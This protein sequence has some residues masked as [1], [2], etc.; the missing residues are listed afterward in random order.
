MR[1]AGKILLA[2]A[3][4]YYEWNDLDAAEQHGVHSL[5]LA[6]QFDRVIDRFILSEVFL[7]RLKMARG[8]V[9]GAAAM[10]AETDRYVR[11]YNFLHRKPDVAAAQVMVL[12]RQGQVAA[13]AEL[14]QQYELPLSKARVYLAQGEPG[15]ALA[16]LEPLRQQ[17]EAQAWADKQ[18]K[19]M[20][21]QAVALRQKGEQ[22]PAAQML[23]EA[24]ALAEPGGFIR[25]FVDEGKPMRQL[26][27]D[28]RSTTEKLA[29]QSL[30]GYVEKILAAFSQPAEATSQ[31]TVKG[32]AAEIIEPLTDRELEILRLIADGQSNTEI[33]QRL[34][35]ALSTVKGHNLRI[36]NK[37]QAQNRT[38]A[39]ARARELGLL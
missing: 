39:V 14:I 27:L 24:L 18:L 33:S 17:A 28:S 3:R 4:I 23:G 30:S 20:V 26:L 32:Q 5:Q 38:E 22:A 1:N 15:A 37:L 25:I 6:R 21:L 29:S 31:A 16:I 2:L 36:F 35:L 9:A 12:L 7:A 8:D 11:Q 10:L 19:T 13:A 34:Y